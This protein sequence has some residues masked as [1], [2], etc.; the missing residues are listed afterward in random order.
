MRGSSLSAGMLLA[1]ASLLS[2]KST[3]SDTTTY[4]Y[5]PLGR[6]VQVSNSGSVNNGLSSSY[7]Y[8][9]A[10]NRSNVT[11]TGTSGVPIFNVSDASGGEGGTIQ[12]TI[13]K[14]G[15]TSSSFTV[16]FATA[17]GTA[18]AGSD[19]NAVSSSVTFLPGDTAKTVDVL[20]IDD[21]AVEGAEGFVLNISGA[22]GAVI[23][24]S[25]GA[26]TIND[27]DV[28]PA[29]SFAI[30]DVSVAEGGNLVLTVTKTGST[31]SSFSVNFA[32]ANGTATAGTDYTAVSGTLTFA[33]TD[34]TKPITI[35][36]TDDSNVESDETVL[37]NLSGATGG[38][39]ITDSQGIG[40]ISNNDSAP[41]CSGVSFTITSNGA[42]MEGANSDFTVSKSGSTSNDCSVSYASANGTATSGSDYTSSSGTLTFSSVQVSLPISVATIDDTAVESAETFSISLSSPS[43]GATLGSPSSATATINS[44]DSAPT[45]NGV[46]FR[47]NDV[48][49][50]EGT[51]LVFTITKTGTASGSCSVSYAS[52]NGTAITPNDYAAVSGTLTFAAN[53]T[54]KTVS[55]TT[56]T[57]GPGEGT[58]NMYLN[59]SNPT[60]GATLFD[61]QGV[62]TIYNYFDDGGGCP[63]C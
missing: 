27:N 35:V 10:G 55:I 54:T 62:G 48:A 41:P 15:A 45:C 43:G 53:E 29:P 19:Y 32:T 38:A 21:S 23:N 22:A 61:S 59:L 13:S 26:G 24:D 34:V 40:T 1:L 49:N 36:T 7:S 58:E 2:T 52:A 39:T 37:V 20:T 33:A 14:S 30:N 51:P 17:N 11:V 60:G 3:A 16:N 18:I 25:Q 50:D 4:S 28:P 9:P 42:V 44:N 6:L 8:D 31:S 5:D 56:T 47:V 57:T 63:L 12:F 46:N